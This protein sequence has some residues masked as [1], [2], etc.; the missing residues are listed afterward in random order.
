M[1]WSNPYSVRL[2]TFYLFIYFFCRVAMVLFTYLEIKEGLVD[3]KQSIFSVTPFATK[4][5][6][7]LNPSCKW[8]YIFFIILFSVTTQKSSLNGRTKIILCTVINI[9]IYNVLKDSAFFWG[10]GQTKSL[11]K[12][13]GN[14]EIRKKKIIFAWYPISVLYLIFF[15]GCMK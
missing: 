5:I 8:T 3:I 2:F 4:I 14:L 12:V 6:K 1:F 13:P 7:P 10:G 15:K 11:M 9:V